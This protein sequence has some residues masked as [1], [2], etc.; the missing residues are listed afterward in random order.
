MTMLPNDGTN[1]YG[2]LLKKFFLLIRNRLDAN[3]VLGASPVFSDPDL[4]NMATVFNQMWDRE[5]VGP[6]SWLSKSHVGN[7]RFET[8]YAKRAFVGKA[9]IEGIACRMKRDNTQSINDST[10]TFVDFESVGYDDRS[11]ADL[12]NNF[13]TIPETGRYLINFFVRWEANATGYRSGIIQRSTSGGAYTNFAPIDHRTA[14]TGQISLNAGYDERWL[15]EGDTLKL[16]V[17]Q[18]S[19]GAL[20]VINAAL[21]VRQTRTVEY[22]GETE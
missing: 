7:P 22:P 16:L 3:P 2:D 10:D 15:A 19:G 11:F 14:V 13:I 6:K 9:A 5:T 21:L 4:E 18:N 12:A 8:L 17:K 20:N 1:R